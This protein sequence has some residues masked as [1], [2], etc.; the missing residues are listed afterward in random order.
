MTLTLKIFNHFSLLLILSVPLLYARPAY[1][2]PSSL[3]EIQQ[4]FGNLC[5]EYG[6]E[7]CASPPKS[8]GEG[9]KRKEFTE[10]EKQ[11]LTRLS[12]Q[13]SRLQDREMDLDRREQQLK[14]LHEDVQRQISQLEKLQQEIERDIESKK[15]QDDALL[16]KAVSFYAKMDAATAAQSINQLDTKVAISILMRMKEKQAAEVLSNIPPNQSAKL[17]AEIAKKK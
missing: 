1:S 11:I 6:L 15:T 17:I 3:E 14:A 16:D 7:F 2:I 10:T 4:K 5:Y 8:K 13:Q 9:D 12:R